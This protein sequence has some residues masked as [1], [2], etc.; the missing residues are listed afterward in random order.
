MIWAA[1]LIMLLTCRPLWFIQDLIIIIIL[2]INRRLFKIRSTNEWEKTLTWLLQTSSVPPSLLHWPSYATRG[3]SLFSPANH[4][5]SKLLIA[6]PPVKDKLLVLFNNYDPMPSSFP[7]G[8]WD[9]VCFFFDVCSSCNH[10]MYALCPTRL[11]HIIPPQ[12]PFFAA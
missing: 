7:P 10:L 12:C 6:P 3:S 1:M 4:F 2:D 8:L 11:E 9:T 5:H